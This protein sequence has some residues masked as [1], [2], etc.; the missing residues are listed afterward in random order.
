MLTDK[1]YETIDVNKMYKAE[2]KDA[3]GNRKIVIEDGSEL[4]EEENGGYDVLE[5]HPVDGDN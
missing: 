4:M 3:F 1:D 5:Y 2:I